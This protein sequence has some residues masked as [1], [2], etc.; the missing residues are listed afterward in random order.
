M[1]TNY[2]CTAKQWR[3]EQATMPQPITNAHKLGDAKRCLV[4]R[5]FGLLRKC[6]VAGVVGVSLQLRF[7]A[8][9]SEMSK[10]GIRPEIKA[11][12]FAF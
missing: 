8:V 2:L 5:L 1:A 6:C 7:C 12:H 9:G 4:V 3:K 11:I 10:G